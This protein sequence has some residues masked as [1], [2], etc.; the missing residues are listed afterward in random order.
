MFKR[1]KHNFYQGYH[2]NIFKKYFPNIIRDHKNDYG[3]YFVT[4]TFENDCQQLYSDGALEYFKAFYQKINQ[5]IVNNPRYNGHKKAKMILV[6][7]KS[8]HCVDPNLNGQAHYHGVLMI[9]KELLSKFQ[10]KC[11]RFQP[12]QYYDDHKHDI[13]IIRKEVKFHSEIISQHRVA[14]KSK[15]YSYK[16]YEIPNDDSDL[17]RICSYITKNLGGHTE[18]EC[19]ATLSEISEFQKGVSETRIYKKDE[20]PNFDEGD[21]LLFAD[22]KNFNSKDYQPKMMRRPKNTA[23]DTRDDAVLSEFGATMKEINNRFVRRFYKS[24]GR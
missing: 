23:Y 12:L 5:N 21:V 4:F 16:C 2:N 7:E 19:N 10:K 3:L 15:V 17:F 20:K 8:Y 9:K 14:Y 11:C 13:H 1:M 18:N 24:R 22:V 6:P